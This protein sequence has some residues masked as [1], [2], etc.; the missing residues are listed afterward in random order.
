MEDGDIVS[1]MDT[2]ER[3]IESDYFVPYLAQ[4]PMEPMAATARVNEDGTCEVWACT[5]DPQAARNQVSMTLAH[6]F[7]GVVIWATKG[8]SQEGFLLGSLFVH[9]NT[10]EPVTD[11]I[12]GQDFTIKDIHGSVNGSFATDFVIK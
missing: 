12:I 3:T 11:T 2:A 1:L 8:Q 4:A 7:A 5:Q 9:I 6:V 10:F